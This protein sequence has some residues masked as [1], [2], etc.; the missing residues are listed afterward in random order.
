MLN[1]QE[2]GQNEEIMSSINDSLFILQIGPMNRTKKIIFKTI[3]LFF[4]QEQ[5]LL[6]HHIWFAIV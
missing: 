1:I 2:A 3:L 5:N 4:S 6:V